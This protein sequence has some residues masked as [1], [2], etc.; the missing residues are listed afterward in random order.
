ME[1]NQDF[2]DL[3]NQSSVTAANAI[4]EA[5]V[6]K[7]SKC[8]SNIFLSRLIIKEVS[9]LLLNQGTENI[10]YPIKV[11]ACA[12]CGHILDEDI[13]AYNLESELEETKTKESSSPLIL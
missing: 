9:G 4:L 3:Y 12:K 10:L 1:M 6:K 7:C 5:P 8:G 11:I 2:S 13:K